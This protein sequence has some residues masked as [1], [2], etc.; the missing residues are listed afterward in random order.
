MPGSVTEG[1]VDMYADD[2]TLTVGGM[3]VCEIE[4]KLCNGV[5]KAM[6]WVNA[7]RLVVNLDK[8]S[9]MRIGPR[10]KLNYMYSDDF[11]VTVRGTILKRVKLPSALVY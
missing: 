8:T 2:T 4:E 11:N 5:S 6:K 3:D 9:V 7:N 10:A 1:V